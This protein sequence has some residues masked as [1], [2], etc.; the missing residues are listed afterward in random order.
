MSKLFGGSD[1]SAQDAQIDQNRE[2]LALQAK[3]AEQ[4]RGDIMDIFPGVRQSAQEGFQGA[5]D[6]YGQAIPQQASLLQGGNVAAQNTLLA[7][8]P[9]QNAAILG[10]RVDLSGLA[11]TRQ[12]YSTDFMQQQLPERVA[13]MPENAQNSFLPSDYLS[14]LF[15]SS[16][17]QSLSPLDQA[18]AAGSARDASPNDMAAFNL[19][20]K[21]VD[22]DGYISDDEFRAWGGYDAWKVKNEGVTEDPLAS[23]KGVRW[24]GSGYADAQGNPITSQQ[25]GAQGLTSGAPAGAAGVEGLS[26][27]QLAK[28]LAGL[29]SGNIGAFR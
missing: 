17:G 5:L 13:M 21:D 3:L 18:I 2:V 12:S 28:I 22:E 10:Q 23:Q 15:G 24:T 6:I 16:Q 29:N 1:D 25:S 26:Q 11:P 9:Q 4:A 8:L 27:Q 20:V 7:G 14:G 19:G